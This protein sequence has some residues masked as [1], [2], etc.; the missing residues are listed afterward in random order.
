MQS[1]MTCGQFMFKFDRVHH[2]LPRWVVWDVGE[3]ETEFSACR[4]IYAIDAEYAAQ[5]WAERFLESDVGATT[6]RVKEYKD[7]ECGGR[8]YEY[9]VTA[10]RTTVYH[11]E[12][13]GAKQEN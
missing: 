5:E 9:R 3:G 10:E 6:L 13:V 12:E 8:E 11:V 2:C 4:N 7:Y 1:C